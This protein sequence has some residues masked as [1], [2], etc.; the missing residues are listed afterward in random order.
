M[1]SGISEINSQ[2]A[3]ASALYLS[4][5][6]NVM[7]ALKESTI[8][9]LK[10]YDI[11]ITQTMTEDEAQKII[12][13]KEAEKTQQTQSSQNAETYYDKQIL[14]DAIQLAGDLGLYIGSDTNV[15]TIMD[16]IQNRLAELSS[17]VG[18][19]DNMSKIVEEYTNR[20]D[21]IYA[22]YMNKKDTLSNQIISSLDIMGTT[23]VATAM[24]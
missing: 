3:I 12:N 19:N 14:A 4:T 10:I 8:K 21:Y 22:Q 23:S 7:T 1:T 24:M 16:N 5:T 15:E 13:D 18:D 17:A 2:T 11:E 9:K 20:Y 6:A